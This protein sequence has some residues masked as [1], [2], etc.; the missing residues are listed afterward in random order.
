ME[1]QEGA[2]VL[3]LNRLNVVLCQAMFH[4][5]FIFLRYISSLKKK[6]LLFI[7]YLLVEGHNF[8]SRVCV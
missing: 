2:Q 7:L 1:Q 4:F 3:S 5:S 6:K 8:R